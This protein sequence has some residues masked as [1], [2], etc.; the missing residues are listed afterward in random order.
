MM[1]HSRTA[2]AGIIRLDSL[3]FSPRISVTRGDNQIFIYDYLLNKIAVFDK[4]GMLAQNGSI[5]VLKPRIS[6]IKLMEIAHLD[7][8]VYKSLLPLLHAI[9]KDKVRFEVL[10]WSDDT[11]HTLL[12]FYYPHFRDDDTIISSYIFFGNYVKNKLVSVKYIDTDKFNS[13]YYYFDNTAPFFVK[14]N[15]FYFSMYVNKPKANT[16]L[17]G[18]WH[19][20]GHDDLIFDKYVPVDLPEYYV[21]NKKEYETYGAV[22]RDSLYYSTTYPFIYNINDSS[23]IDLSCELERI[24]GVK[25]FGKDRKKTFFL[26]DVTAKGNMLEFIYFI[27]TIPKIAYYDKT[28]KKILYSTELSLD[29]DLDLP[30]LTFLTPE[31]FMVMNKSRKQILLYK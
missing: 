29:K 20:G 23:E 4:Q 18:E 24:E 5:A 3:A 2:N 13:D 8:N 30:S 19:D 12:T 1:S 15:D 14:N 25:L 7:T 11:L 28:E 27:D 16:K 9:G 21:K 17:F 6:K 31:V 22:L 26:Q 10:S